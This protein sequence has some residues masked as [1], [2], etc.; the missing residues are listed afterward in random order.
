M[1]DVYLAQDQIGRVALKTIR[2]DPDAAR[3]M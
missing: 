1:G 2:V 3:R